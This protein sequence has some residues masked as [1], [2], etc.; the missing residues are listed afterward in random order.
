MEEIR[1]NVSNS[2]PVPPPPPPPPR[3]NISAQ[4][5][6]A[7]QAQ[8]Q[9]SQ[10]QTVQQQ[11]SVQNN[12]YAQPAVNAQGTNKNLNDKKEQK[13]I[14]EIERIKGKSSSKFLTSLYWISFVLALGAIGLLIYMLIR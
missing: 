13:E 11:N 1:N 12:A 14:G 7:Q 2:R 6:Q 5:V 3:P 10:S 9:V 8:S 4:P